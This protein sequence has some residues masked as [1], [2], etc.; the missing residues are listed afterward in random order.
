MCPSARK[1]SLLRRLAFAILQIS[2]AWETTMSEI[3]IAISENL[4][5]WISRKTQSGEYADSSDYVS[6]L[7]R[8][9]QERS[10][11]IAAMQTAVNAG[12]ASGT[13]HRTADELFETARQQA[14]TAG[15]G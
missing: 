5:E 3:T 7:I 4:R 6:D 11:K 8:R 2:K 15:G 12:L 1:V 13:G 9:D 10:A 14:R